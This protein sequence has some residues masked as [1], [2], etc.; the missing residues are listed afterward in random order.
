LVR[1]SPDGMAT[2]LVSRLSARNPAPS[3][4]ATRHYH[5]GLW[6]D[7]EDNVFVAVPGERLVVKVQADGKVSVAARS[8]GGWSPSG[9]MFDPSGNLWLLEYSSTNAVRVRRIDP[10]GNEQIF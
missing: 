8:T 3:A 4:A 5:M 2:T 1:I 7:T 6:V 9:G 10:R